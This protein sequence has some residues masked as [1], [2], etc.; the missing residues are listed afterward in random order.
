MAQSVG[1]LIG[2]LTSIAGKLLWSFVGSMAYG[3]HLLCGK[4]R[5][6]L[7]LGKHKDGR[8]WLN[9]VSE[10]QIAGGVLLFL[11]E[12]FGH[13]DVLLIG[14]TPYERYLEQCAE[15]DWPITVFLE[16][17]ERGDVCLVDQ[18]RRTRRST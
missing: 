13:R 18:I 9:N 2:S 5:K 10:S 6:V 8:F 14:D 3:G 4:C 16:E 1:V 12:H 15:H 17:N 11:Q 7:Y